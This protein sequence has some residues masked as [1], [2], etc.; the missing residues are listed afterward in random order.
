[1]A[2][3]QPDA[4]NRLVG[5]GAEA[6]AA[7]GA[8]LEG[9]SAS[10][11]LETVERRRALISELIPTALQ[12]LAENGISPDGFGPDLRTALELVSV[13]AQGSAAFLLGQLTAVPTRA[14]DP[15]AAST[16]PVRHLHSVPSGPDVSEGVSAQAQADAQAD[17]L[18]ETLRRLTE[19]VENAEAAVARARASFAAL[20]AGAIEATTTLRDSIANVTETARQITELEERR[21]QLLRVQR[22]AEV[23]VETAEIQ[24]EAAQHAL[25]LCHEN[26]NAAERAL[27]EWRAANPT[28]GG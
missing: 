1:M 4:S 19:T 2:S 5:L 21:E 12:A 26:A 14:D 20:S 17:A 27:G 3:L 8:L 10:A 11:V 25:E 13:N 15:P 9:G 23:S 7:Q 22:D 6:L 18:S 24:R 16:L 28:V